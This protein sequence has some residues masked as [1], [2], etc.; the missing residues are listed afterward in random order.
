MIGEYMDPRKIFGQAVTDLA[1]DNKNIIVLSADSGK[2]SGFG[3]FIEKYP[4]RYFECGIMEQGVVGVASGLAAIGKIPVFCA[5]APF[6]T[7]RPYEMLRNDLGYM[8]QNAKIV[9][10]NCGITYSD[11]GAT[12]HSLEDFAIM[13]MIPGMVV[14]A[15]QD[16]CEII[17]AVKAMIDYQGPVYMRIGNPLIPQLFTQRPFVIGKGNVIKVGKDVTIVSTGST[18][19]NVIKAG[20]ILE[21]QG[22]L[23]EII[24]MPTVYPLDEKTIIESAIK[25]KFV[26]TVEEHYVKGGLGT[27][28]SETLIKNDVCAMIRKIGVPHDYAA[29]GPY[30]ELIHYYGLDAEGI[31]VSIKNIV[32]CKK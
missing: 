17:E 8:R 14:L 26:I 24:G 13:S 9:G 11:L 23:A 31:A 3:K 21:A 20:K 18:T 4:D 7:V 19:A 1:E 30:E 16:P 12:H 22:I 6:V 10:R 5:I 25:T 32:N 15:P 27:I 28:V 29:N 2:S